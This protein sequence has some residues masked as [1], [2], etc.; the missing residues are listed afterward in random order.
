[1]ST[2]TT[3]STF[4]ICE[5]SL[6][7]PCT[8][9]VA[10]AVVILSPEQRCNSSQPE[11]PPSQFSKS[12]PKSQPNQSFKLPRASLVPPPTQPQRPSRTDTHSIL[13]HMLMISHQN[14]IQTNFCPG[15]VRK[16]C[17][18]FCSNL[19]PESICVTCTCERLGSAPPRPHPQL[20]NCA[21]LTFNN[22]LKVQAA[23]CIRISLE[24]KVEERAFFFCVFLAVK[25]LRVFYFL[26][27]ALF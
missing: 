12:E 2:F 9:W 16:A 7:S 21:S 14:P 5:T 13:P 15:A 1:M 17:R 23:M 27:R 18:T 22:R 24:I 10:G 8:A 6:M 25:V 19:A 26:S 4:A 11:N 20:G 3:T